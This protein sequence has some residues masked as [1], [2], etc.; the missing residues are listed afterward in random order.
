MTFPMLI[1]VTLYIECSRNEVQYAVLKYKVHEHK[2]LLNFW[3][4]QIMKD[5]LYQINEWDVHANHFNNKIKFNK[6]PLPP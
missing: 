6:V 5:F 2:F 1:T 3:N 4:D